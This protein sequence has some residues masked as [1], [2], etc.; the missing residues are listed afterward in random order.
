MIYH[1]YKGIVAS[2]ILGTFGFFLIWKGITGDIIKTIDGKAFIP[3]WMYILGGIIVL[4]LPVAFLIVQL[5][6]N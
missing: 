5:G 1:I 6:I 4:I 2:I 3:K